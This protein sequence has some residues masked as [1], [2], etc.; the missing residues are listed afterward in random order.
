MY[1]DGLESDKH[2]QASHLSAA[3]INDQL[4]EAWALFRAH[5]QVTLTVNQR[6]YLVEKYNEDDRSG[7]T[8]NAKSVVAAKNLRT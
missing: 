2:K 1:K 5:P 6:S 4:I 3:S 8:R 7:T